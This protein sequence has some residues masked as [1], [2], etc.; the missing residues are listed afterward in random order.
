MVFYFLLLCCVGLGW[1]GWSLPLSKRTPLNNLVLWCA[2]VHGKDNPLPETNNWWR[3][4]KIRLF[5]DCHFLFF[6]DTFEQSC[7]VMRL[8]AWEGQS[9][10][11]NQQLMKTINNKAICFYWAGHAVRSLPL[12]KQTHLNN[13]ALCCAFV[14]EKDNTLPETN[15][16]W[17][18]WKTRFF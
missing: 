4:Y 13:I 17:R 7:F 6:I 11:R 8:C 2:F 14:H 10:S 3:Q 18:Q 5:F 9:T 15:N 16:W 12:S 1:G